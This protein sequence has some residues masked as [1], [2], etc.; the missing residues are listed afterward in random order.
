AWTS[1]YTVKLFPDANRPPI[2]YRKSPTTTAACEVLGPVKDVVARQS[3]SSIPSAWALLDCATTPAAPK[4]AP[5]NAMARRRRF[6][7]SSVSCA[8]QRQ[9]DRDRSGLLAGSAHLHQNQPPHTGPSYQAAV[10]VVPM[11]ASIVISRSPCSNASG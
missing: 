1:S 9:R 6:I 4:P 10:P 7:G 8:T 2:T 11:S 3:W 5:R